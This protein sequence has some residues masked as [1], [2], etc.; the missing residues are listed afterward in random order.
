MV[1]VLMLV[2][3]DYAVSF[4]HFNCELGKTD[5]LKKYQ[6]IYVNGKAVK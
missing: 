1:I 3:M 5:T 2:K 6:L 4:K